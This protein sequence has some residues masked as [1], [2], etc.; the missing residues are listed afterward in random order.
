VRALIGRGSLDTTQR[1]S[2]EIDSH[3]VREIATLLHGQWAGRRWR[4]LRRW[5]HRSGAAD[6]GRAAATDVERAVRRL[7][8][9][10]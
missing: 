6:L 3:V 5:R 8:S 2:T 7:V 10:H 4:R 9:T 1:H